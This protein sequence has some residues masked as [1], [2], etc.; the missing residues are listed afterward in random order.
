MENETR[1]AKI[2]G[3]WYARIPPAF[4]QHLELTEEKANGGIPAMIKD[5]TNKHNQKYCSLWKKEV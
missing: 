2:S 5:E 4:A 1:F 3:S